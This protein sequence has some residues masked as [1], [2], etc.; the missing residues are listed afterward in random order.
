MEKFKANQVHSNE[1]IYIYQLL[2][3]KFIKNIQL[4]VNGFVNPES[5]QSNWAGGTAKESTTTEV[6]N[7]C[8]NSGDLQNEK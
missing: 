6:E 5:P 3:V 7:R 1:N 8:R 2:I 4:D